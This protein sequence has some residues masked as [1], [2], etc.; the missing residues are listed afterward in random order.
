MWSLTI[1]KKY[2]TLHLYSLYAARQFSTLNLVPLITKTQVCKLGTNTVRWHWSILFISRL[3]RVLVSFFSFVPEGRIKGRVK[4]T[5]NCVVSTNFS[6]R[7]LK[8]HTGS[9]SFIWT[10]LQSLKITNLR[11]SLSTEIDDT[12]LCRVMDY[13][14][15]MTSSYHI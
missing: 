1:D 12:S 15:P 7:R 4:V 10:F 8:T 9:M 13:I 14:V 11:R 5:K 6:N 2:G 3:Q